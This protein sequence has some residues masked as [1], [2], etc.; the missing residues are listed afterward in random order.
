MF[1]ICFVSCC[2]LLFLS[3][4][5]PSFFLA[6]PVISSFSFGFGFGL[7]HLTDKHEEPN[8]LLALCFCS[9]RPFSV[10]SAD[11][12][13]VWFSAFVFLVAWLCVFFCVFCFVLLCAICP[14]W[15]CLCICSVVV[16]VSL[17]LCICCCV[18]VREAF[19]V[20]FSVVCLWSV[21]VVPWAVVVLLSLSYLCDGWCECACVHGWVCGDGVACVCV[22]CVMCD[23]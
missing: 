23:V 19:A 3:L 8:R 10:V 13:S 14:C 17:L 22:W 7:T 21:L 4:S 1:S 11:T 9:S 12:G 18:F 20:T 15:M 5:Y 16:F 6:C 2:C